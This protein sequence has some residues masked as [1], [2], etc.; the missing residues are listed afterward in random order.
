MRV[1]RLGDGMTADPLDIK[2]GV[3]YSSRIPDGATGQGQTLSQALFRFSLL[4][5]GAP[6]AFGYADSG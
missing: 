4:G 6:I 5:Y 2:L 3:G 1:E